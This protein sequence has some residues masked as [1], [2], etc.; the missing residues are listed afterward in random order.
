MSDT[1][2]KNCR[3]TNITSEKMIIIKIFRYMHVVLGKKFLHD[4]HTQEAHFETHKYCLWISKKSKFKQNSLFVGLC[5]LCAYHTAYLVRKQKLYDV[6]RYL[7]YHS[8]WSCTILV[9][10]SRKIRKCCCISLKKA[11]SKYVE[12]PHVFVKKTNSKY[13][14][15]QHVFAKKKQIQSTLK[16]RMF[17]ETKIIRTM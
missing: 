17:F 2:L 8:I 13:V 6:L 4:V 3:I 16:T 1:F 15:N 12:N 11:F 5:L 10:W 14:E 7:Y 9:K